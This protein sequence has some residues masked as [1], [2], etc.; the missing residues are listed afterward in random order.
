MQEKKAMTIEGLDVG[1]GFD[2]PRLSDFI[3][4]GK[5]S[6]W[7]QHGKCKLL[8][9]KVLKIGSDRSSNGFTGFLKIIL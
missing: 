6:I 5:L 4:V 9:T 3:I 1:R 7:T 2:L 8:S